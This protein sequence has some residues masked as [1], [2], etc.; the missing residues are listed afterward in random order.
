M[1]GSD[2]WPVRFSVDTLCVLWSALRLKL[3]FITSLCYTRAPVCHTGCPRSA[4]QSTLPMMWGQIHCCQHRAT[5]ISFDRGGEN[6][7]AL[8]DQPASLRPIIRPYQ[9]PSAARTAAGYVLEASQVLNI[10]LSKSSDSPIAVR[11]SYSCF[12]LP[13]LRN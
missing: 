11:R 13:R 7:Y 10:A 1:L 5:T 6:R 9:S 8:S 4:I 2:C 12:K 3:G